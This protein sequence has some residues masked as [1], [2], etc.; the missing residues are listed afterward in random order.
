MERDLMLS[1]YATE[2]VSNVYRYTNTTYLPSPT[3]KIYLLQVLISLFRMFPTRPMPML[4][5]RLFQLLLL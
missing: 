1:A 4:L 3:S 2:L 5:F